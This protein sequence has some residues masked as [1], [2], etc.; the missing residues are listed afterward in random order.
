MTEQ[1]LLRYTM[2]AP[3]PP[4]HPSLL[5]SSFR[6]CKHVISFLVASAVVAQRC[7]LEREQAR[8]SPVDGSCVKESRDESQADVLSEGPWKDQVPSPGQ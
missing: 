6:T 5:A 2:S 3:P 7:A 4:P 8:S 1:T